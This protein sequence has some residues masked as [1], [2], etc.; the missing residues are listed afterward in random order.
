MKVVTALLLLLKMTTN[1]SPASSAV[2]VVVDQ[3]IPTAPSITSPIA[4]TQNTD[5]TEISG[6]SEE[7]GLTIEVFDGATSLGPA[8]EL[9]MV[10]GQLI[11]QI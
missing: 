6:T 3:T 1:T 4:G 2:A 11:S 7:E 9:L 10:L 5:I 8:T